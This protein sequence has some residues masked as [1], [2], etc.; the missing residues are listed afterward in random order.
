MGVSFD[1]V[2]IGCLSHNP[3]WNERQP[4][5]ALHATTTLIRDGVQTILVDPSLPAELLRHRLDERTG[6]KPEQITCVFLTSFQPDHRRSLNLFERAE[7]LMHETEIQAYR[8][9]LNRFLDVAQNKER[10]Q[11]DII[12]QELELLERIR[13]APEKLTAAVHLF[14]TPGVT[15][16]SCSLLLVPATTTVAVAGDAVVNRDYLEHGRVFERCS[17]AAQAAE[18]LAE[19]IEIADQI[20]CGHDNVLIPQGRGL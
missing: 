20:V 10:D 18:S 4:V 16:G 5:R 2:S 7:W 1:V 8:D 12:R 15:P 19:L 3:F 14:P 9:H 6:L 11:V 13:R 17:D